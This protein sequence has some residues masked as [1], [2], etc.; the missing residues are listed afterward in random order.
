MDQRARPSRTPGS[1]RA[2]HGATSRRWYGNGLG[3]AHACQ[4][5]RKIRARSDECAHRHGVQPGRPRREDV[6]PASSCTCPAASVARTAQPVGPRLLRRPGQHPLAPGV[7]RRD[8]RQPGRLPGAAV[9]LHLDLGH[10]DVLVPGHPGDRDGRRRRTRS[11]PSRAGRC[12][13]TSGS[14]GGRPTRPA[15]STAAPSRT[16]S[17]RCRPPTC[18]PTRSRR[19]PGR[20]RAPGSRARAATA[21]RSCPRPAAPRGR[22]SRP[23]SGR[24]SSCRPRSHQQLVGAAVHPGL[25]Q[26]VGQQRAAEQRVAD[27]LAADLVRD[28]AQ[29]D[30][31]L[32]QRAAQQLR[33]RS[34]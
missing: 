13:T 14:A 23:T 16:S 21:R 10:A 8:G 26:Q 4:R 7:G 17:P 11:P 3:G 19:D 28:A 33:R 18:R 1:S 5:R 34:G 20:R 12:A 6:A 29:R 24:R 32:D 30:P 27:Q 31:A 2:A 9:D 15:P 22:P 25:A